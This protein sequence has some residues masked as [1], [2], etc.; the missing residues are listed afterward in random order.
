[1]R[2]LLQDIRYGVRTLLRKPGFTVAAIIALALG[3]GANTAIFSFV[4]GV[5][6]RPLPY[7]NQDRIQLIFATSVQQNLSEMP[8][9]AAD[10]LEI[11]N[12][13]RSFEKVGGYLRGISF[14]LLRPEGAQ[15]FAG[16]VATAG[17]FEVL[18]VKPRIGRTFEQG[19]EASSAPS[20]VVISERLWRNQFNADPGIV[21]KI[22][23]FSSGPHTV[24]GVMPAE[25]QYP[26]DAIDVWRNYRFAATMSRE[27]STWALARLRAD[28]SRQQAQDELAS[29]AAQLQRAFPATNAGRGFVSN[30]LE[31]KMLGDLR[32]PL[33]VLLGAVAFVLLIATAN[34]ANLMLARSTT[35]DK[36]VAI[37]TAL[38]AGRLRIARQ[39][40]TES[41]VLAAAGGLAGLAIAQWSL[42]AFMALAPAGTPRLNQVSVDSAVLVFTSVIS[43]V[44]GLLFGIFPALQ[45]KLVD[46]NSTLK[47][48]GRGSAVSGS[49]SF[50]R[51]LVVVEIALSLVLLTG[52]G[53]TLR[54]FFRL[55]QVETGF[56][57]KN[58][59]AVRMG[60]NPAK[61]DT[62]EKTVALYEEAQRRLSMLPGVQVTGI[63]NSLPP[64]QN[65]ANDS[66]TIEGRPGGAGDEAP[67]AAVLLVDPGYF[68]TLNIPILRG[69]AFLN[70]DRANAPRVA[71]ISETLANR[72]FPNEDPVGKRMRI[73]GADRPDTPWMEIVGVVKDVRYD[74]LKGPIDPA[75]YMPYAQVP[76]RGQ[77]IV[78]KT[79]GDPAS[80]AN[81][82][83]AEIRAVDADIPLLHVTTLEQR[84]SEAVGEPRFQT[85]L[86]AVFSGIALLLSAIGI[87]AVIS[88]SITLRTHEIGVRM[89]LGASRSDVL[90]MVVREG[91]AL[92]IIGAVAGLA[93]ALALTRFM[94]GVLFEVSP[95]DPLTFAAVSGIMLGVAFLAC[96]IPARR[97]TRVDPMIAL[98]YE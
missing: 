85:T 76:Q 65:D 1:M 95:R 23:N 86:L 22:V 45:T 36:E 6:L 54:S 20:V 97:A 43:L 21:G 51:A 75:Y 88:Y 71:M 32:T 30:P 34:V 83:R 9:S 11:R 29:V 14:T 37:R 60:V 63:T 68:K 13:V 48:G 16:A 77:D 52:A 41:V 84:M 55:R 47:E 5:L 44:S 58:V 33:Y 66:F 72:H 46:L 8:L 81:A 26:S 93:G 27:G 70:T 15:S 25:V 49:S 61:Y 69:R 31:E 59:L 38:G 94:A 80:L 4:H 18:G 24:I 91:M 2:T 35:R 40:L 98:R 87:Y 89:S 73:G 19:D 7:P 10:Y 92:A 39:L 78:I 79:A 12:R 56:D 28:S 53:I 74:G 90:R 96:F 67:F 62:R 3:I 82:V 50:R 57:S 42:D 64:I 17:F